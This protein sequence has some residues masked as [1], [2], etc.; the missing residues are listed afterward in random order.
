LQEA[1]AESSPGTRKVVLATNVAE[2]SV[3]IPGVVYGT[4]THTHTHTHMPYTHT[5]GGEERG[6]KERGSIYIYIYIY[7]YI[8]NVYMFMFVCV[9]IN[10]SGGQHVREDEVIQREAGHRHAHSHASLQSIRSACEGCLVTCSLVSDTGLTCE[11]SLVTCRTT[12][13]PLSGLELYVAMS[14]M[15][16]GGRL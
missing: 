4:H 8:C 14:C 7:I 6:R 10:D 2:T 16:G 5:R 9:H 3:T 12:L 15:R 13:A 11:P 1:F